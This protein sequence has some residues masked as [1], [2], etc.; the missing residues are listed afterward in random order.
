[1]TITEPSVPEPPAPEPAAPEPAAP[2]PAA[3]ERTGVTFWIALIMGGAVMAF[4]IR[5]VITEFGREQST[6][7]ATWVIGADLLHD[8]LIAPIAILVGWSVVRLAPRRWR[9]PLNAGLLATGIVLGIAWPALRGYGRAIVPDN[10]S[11]QPLDY[12]TAVAWVLGVVWV[13][14]A[15]WLVVGSVRTSGARSQR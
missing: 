3:S 8:L 7:L 14:V 13:A 1:M 11:V 15:I 12:S 2:E 4:G 5:G 6:N 9:A 10:P